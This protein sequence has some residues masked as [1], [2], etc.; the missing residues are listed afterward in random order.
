MGSHTG[1]VG[2]DISA[3]LP[4]SVWPFLY[5]LNYR[6]SVL[7]VFWSFAEIVVL[8]VDVNCIL[9]VFTGGV[10]SGSSYSALLI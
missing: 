9:G 1:G 10:G 8:N 3:P 7:L 6:K 5:V 4:V 2:S